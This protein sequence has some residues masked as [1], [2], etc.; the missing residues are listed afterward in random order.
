MNSNY[1]TRLDGRELAIGILDF[2]GKPSH[3]SELS[4]KVCGR[5]T[6]YNAAAILERQG[7]FEDVILGL[8]SETNPDFYKLVVI[9][10]RLKNA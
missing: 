8:P 5:D 9:K 3:V 6:F 2:F 4:V 1:S 10:E 7:L